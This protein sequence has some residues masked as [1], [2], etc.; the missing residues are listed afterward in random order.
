VKFDRRLS[1]IRVSTDDFY[2]THELVVLRTTEQRS[3]SR[4]GGSITSKV[5]SEKDGIVSAKLL[6]ADSSRAG[7]PSPWYNFGDPPEYFP[8]P[9]LLGMHRLACV[10]PEQHY[11]VR[12]PGIGKGEHHVLVST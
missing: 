1:L 8:T 7:I 3:A 11:G 12:C 9:N 10:A 5:P 6:R 4:G 2:T